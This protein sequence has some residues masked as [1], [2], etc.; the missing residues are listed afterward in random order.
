MTDRPQATAVTEFKNAIEFQNVCFSYDGKTE[1]LKDISF[2]AE[3]GRVI[4]L[5][6][7]SGGGK[8]TLVDLLARFYD[9]VKGAILVDGTDL[10]RIS[11]GTFR[12]L[13][14]L[15]TQETIL[16]YDTI[17]TNIA[18]GVENAP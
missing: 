5:V 15:V 12:H 13:L 14:G 16:F 7:P 11:L 17:A 8:S 4:A 2:T 1:V 3:K 9:P 18:Y 10:R 6:G